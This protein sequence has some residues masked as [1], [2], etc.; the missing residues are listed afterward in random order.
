MPLIVKNQYVALEEKGQGGFG[1]TFVALDLDSPGKVLSQ[2]WRRILKLL[3]PSQSL[4]ASSLKLVEGL[5]R[6]EAEA[7]EEL[8]HN[9]IPRLYAFFNLSVPAYSSSHNYSS[10]REQKLFYLVQEYIE[11]IDLDKELRQRQEQGKKF[12]LEEVVSVLHEVLGI[13]NFIHAN[14]KKPLI[15]RDIKPSNIVRRNDDKQLYLIDFGTVKQVIKVVEEGAAQSDTVIVS[16]GYSPPEQTHGRT[17]TFASDLYSLAATCITL[18]TGENPNNFNIPYNLEKW[19]TGVI[20]NPNLVKIIN[21]MLAPDPKQRY[22]SAN[23]VIAALRKTGLLETEKKLVPLWIYGILGVLGATSAL[24]A[25]STIVTPQQLPLQSNYFTRGEESLLTQNIKS[26]SATCQEAFAKKQAGMREFANENFAASE[27]NFQAAIDLFRLATREATSTA[28]CYVDPETQI[29]LNN[30]KARNSNKPPLTVAVVTPI[31]GNSV[32]FSKLSE[33]ILRGAAQVQNKFNLKSGI[34]GRLL[35][36]MIVRDNN[37]RSTAQRAA[38]HLAETKIPGDKNFR[39]SVIAVI[40]NLNSDVVLDAGKEYENG[41]LVA[42]S[43]TSTAIRQKQKTSSSDYQFN[44]SRYVFRVI[45]TD[46]VAANDLFKYTQKN[47][48]GKKGAIFYSS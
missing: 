24:Y 9:Q 14:P 18:L 39:G 33:Q 31:N 48:A 20:V 7:L 6:K 30:A 35:E 5:F 25:I 36:I 4:S 19:K 22:Q 45:P 12:S 29:F 8:K 2:K 43:T 16:P 46:T 47:F 3:H 34:N 23:E 26:T 28:R 13:L 27:Q 42:I 21:K 17:V 44:L 11:G 37:D 15:H 41:K 40:G 32:E 1:K 10:N 38:R